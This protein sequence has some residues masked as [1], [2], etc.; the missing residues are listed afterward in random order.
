MYVQS[1][2]LASAI[3]AELDWDPVYK[4]V[5]FYYGKSELKYFMKSGK[6]W[7]NNKFIEPTNKAFIENGRSYIPLRDFSEILGFEL[8]YNPNEKLIYVELGLSSLDN[9]NILSNG[10]TRVIFDFERDIEYEIVEKNSKS[11]VID[12]FGSFIDPSR[13]DKTVNSKSLESFYLIQ[14]NPST[15]R[16]VFRF[17]ET[18][19][20]SVVPE[21]GSRFIF[22][23]ETGAPLPSNQSP[24]TEIAEQPS[25]KKTAE[26]KE[27]IRVVLDP[28][29]GGVDS[30]A[31]GIFGGLEKDIVL[32][33]AQLLGEKLIA[34]GKFE[35]FYTRTEDEYV[36]LYDRA[37]FAND[38]KADLFVSLHLNSYTEKTVEGTEIYYFDFSEDGYVRR[39]VWKENLD[40][41]K[42][43]DKIAI[44][45]MK[46][47]SYTKESKKIAEYIL[48]EMSKDG[49]KVRSV[50]KG[51]FAVLAY[52]EM[53]S[54]LIEC[55]FISNPVV[56]IRLMTG[57]YSD[58]LA[59]SIA[60]AIEGYFNNK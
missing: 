49:L 23:F 4:C 43:K 33:I 53:P 6:V 34:T 18:T 59:E 32:K 24:E 21:N 29:H 30:G 19:R 54:I 28:G 38:V 31:V 1:A 25:E 42:D 57:E 13:I 27:K 36:N 58:K 37:K 17:D 48:D 39:I 44:R 3:G 56:E 51:E 9:L 40:P 20:C 2:A 16:A 55:D 60:K 12:F 50:K 11:L 8:K 14:F 46:K 45:V 35:V 47:D 52:T 41:V 5:I 26:T 15:V 7:Y 10:K 22:D